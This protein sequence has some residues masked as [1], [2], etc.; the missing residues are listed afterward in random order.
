MQYI[1]IGGH[2][3][4]SSIVYASFIND[5]SC[6][7][8]YEPQKN[9]FELLVKN[10]NQNNLQTKIKSY[11]LAIFCNNN[12]CQMNSIDLDGGGG[13]VSKRYNEE[14]HLPCNFGGMD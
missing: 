3:G 1:R 4:T 6:V 5:N 9:L 10:V 7:Y 11:N 2:C 12:T 14:K 13:I 8:V